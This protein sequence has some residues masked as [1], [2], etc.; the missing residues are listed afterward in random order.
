MKRTLISHFCLFK[1][2][3]LISNYSTS[4]GSFSFP[5]VLLSSPERFCTLK[6]KTRKGLILGLRYFRSVF[7]KS[8]FPPQEPFPLLKITETPKEICWH[9]LYLSIFTI[10]TTFAI[11]KINMPLQPLTM[12]DRILILYYFPI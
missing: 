12:F 3:L 10:L 9:G 7:L 1:L 6:N 8:F 5:T 4:T 2:Y 11:L